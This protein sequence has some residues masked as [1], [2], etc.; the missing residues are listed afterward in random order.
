MRAR[1]GD[2]VAVT[3][4]LGSRVIPAAASLIMACA[5]SV[6]WGAADLA[7]SRNAR[8]VEITASRRGFAP[9]HVTASVG[10][11]IRLRFVRVSAS[12]CAKEIVLHLDPRRTVRRPLPMSRPV[13]LTVQLKRAGEIG[14]TC[15]MTMH[16]GTI[17][18]R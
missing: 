15:G 12:S 1:P 17:D 5:S 6:Q 16:G 18:I 13:E 3:T 10:E 2:H 9:E 11:H 7:E 4:T 8:V 14:F